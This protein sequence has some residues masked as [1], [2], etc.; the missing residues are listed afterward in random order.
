MG[1]VKEDPFCQAQMHVHSQTG[2]VNIG[3]S[4][5]PLQAEV[6]KAFAN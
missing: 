2:S 5:Q 1:D 3:S 4:L 6:L